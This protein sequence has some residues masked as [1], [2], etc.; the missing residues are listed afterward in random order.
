MRHRSKWPP[1][2]LIALFLAAGAATLFAPE[3]GPR[4]ACVASAVGDDRTIPDIVGTWEGTWEDTIYMVSGSMSWTI[5]PDRYDY[6]GSGTI[7]LTAL[8]LG[9]QEGS[10]GGGITRQALEFTYEANSVGSGNGV[11]TGNSLVGD[12]LVTAPLNFGYFTFRGTVTSEAAEGR[13]FFVSPTGGAGRVTMTNTTPV[14]STSWGSI[15]AG[16]RNDDE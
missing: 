7:D 1:L 2:F 14:E 11:L 13:F 9:A 4:G 3:A 10:A 12:G 8:G 15:K 5:S 16:Y 6:I